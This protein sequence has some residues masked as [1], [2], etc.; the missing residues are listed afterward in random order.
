MY[1]ELQPQEKKQIVFSWKSFPKMNFDGDGQYLLYYQKQAGTEDYPLNIKMT[2]PKGIDLKTS[3][4]FTLT[5]DDQYSYN[6]SL[7]RDLFSRIYWK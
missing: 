4:V 2:V 6:T 3:P 7:S 5:N 1:L